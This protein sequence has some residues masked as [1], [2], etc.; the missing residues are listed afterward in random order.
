[1]RPLIDQLKQPHYDNY[2]RKIPFQVMLSDWFDGIVPSGQAPVGV[3][4]ALMAE[5][6][7]KKKSKPSSVPTQRNT[8]SLPVF[9][10]VSPT[11][12]VDI[13]SSRKTPTPQQAES[14]NTCQAHGK[15][16]QRGSRA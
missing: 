7:A 9:R 10:F 12:R 5:L 2:Y 3:I 1:M 11:V 6:T 13:I 16:R 14:S 4:K 8:E 15:T